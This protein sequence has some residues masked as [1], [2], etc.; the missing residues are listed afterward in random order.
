MAAP[1]SQLPIPH[2]PVAFVQSTVQLAR[3]PQSTT[4]SSV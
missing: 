4:H 2:T 1:L 3:V